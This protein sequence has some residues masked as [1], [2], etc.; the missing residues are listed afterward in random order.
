MIIVNEVSLFPYLSMLRFP[1]MIARLVT[2]L[3]T[4]PSSHPGLVVATFVATSFLRC[5]MRDADTSSFGEVRAAFMVARLAATMPPTRPSSY[6]GLVVATIMA[7]DWH[8][9]SMSD[10]DSSFDGI[11]GTSFMTAKLTSSPSVPG[12]DSSF[13]GLVGASFFM[14]T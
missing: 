13:D 14:A 3:P 7:A 9:C 1:F 6:L 10:A 12:A 11:V 5:P 2:M 8:L 4:K